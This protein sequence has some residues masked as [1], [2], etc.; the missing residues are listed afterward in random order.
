[1]ALTMKMEKQSEE[2]GMMTKQDE[3]NRQNEIPLPTLE[4]MQRE[5]GS[6]KSIDDFFGKE[7][8][9]SRLFARTLEHMLEA[10]LTSEL[11]YGKYEAK[12]HNSGNSRNGKY[13]RKVKTSGGEAEIAVPR[14]RNGEFE[15]VSRQKIWNDRSMTLTQNAEMLGVLRETLNVQA[16]RLGLKQPK[17]GIP[18]QKTPLLN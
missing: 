5:L 10:E 7:G 16:I 11:G 3:Q 15:P 6:A 8:I 14:D 2:P 13:Q 4:E 1:M 17:D 12:G 18:P 9:F